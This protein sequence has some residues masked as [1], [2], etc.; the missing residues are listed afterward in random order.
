MS[1]DVNPKLGDFSGPLGSIYLSKRAGPRLAPPVSS[2][3]AS[4]VEK[5]LSFLLRAGGTAAHSDTL[6]AGPRGKVR[7]GRDEG[8]GR[9]SRG[10][11]PRNPFTLWSNP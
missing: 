4:Q 7:W 1:P 5:D 6:D 8:A 11:P 9:K 2:G 10:D 3:K